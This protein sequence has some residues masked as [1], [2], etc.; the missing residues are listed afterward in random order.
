M[1][2]MNN[3]D[4]VLDKYGNELKAGDSVCFIHKHSM[5]SQYIVK[6]IVAEVKPMKKDKD[7]PNLNEN[8]GWV[9]IDKYVDEHINN[10]PKAKNK[11]SADRVV[12]CYQFGTICVYTII[13]HLTNKKMI[14]YI[15]SVDELWEYMEDKY[16]EGNYTE[17][18]SSVSKEDYLDA[19]EKYGWDL[20]LDEFVEEFNADGNYAP[21]NQNHFIRFY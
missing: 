9:I 5:E 2:T 18:I 12:K 17:T 4:K 8:R 14:V 7:F 1:N 13:E 19:C 21:T 6:A 10:S 15:I 11:V 16:G 3:M 20:T